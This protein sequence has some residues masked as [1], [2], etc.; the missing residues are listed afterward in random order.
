MIERLILYKNG[1]FEIAHPIHAQHIEACDEDFLL[2]ADADDQAL[3]EHALKPFEAFED[4]GAGYIRCNSGD[5]QAN[6]VM[7]A[8]SAIRV[9]SD[10][11]LECRAKELRV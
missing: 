7:L 2:A 4:S 3:L 1:S 5:K 11:L 8:Q 6:S 9:M 10:R